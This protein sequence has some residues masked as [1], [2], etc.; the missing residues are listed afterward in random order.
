MVSQPE[1]N[2]APIPEIVTS[3]SGR[4]TK[5]QPQVPWIALL[6]I[7]CIGIFYFATLRSGHTWGDDFAMYVRH[8]KNLAEGRTYSDTGYIYNPL[9]PRLGPPTY[10]PVFPL[11]LTP[12]YKFA[13]L[14][15]VALKVVAVAC[16]LGALTLLVFV[17]YRDLTLG[18]VV[19]VIAILGLNPFFFDYKDQIAS[20]LPFL[21]F[22]LIAL[23]LLD[24][25]DAKSGWPLALAAGLSICLCTATRAIGLALLPSFL[26]YSLLRER[27]ITAAAIRVSLVALASTALYVWSFRGPV[28]YLDQLHITAA[29]IGHNLYFQLWQIYNNLWGN[30]FS[31]ALA[32][33]L[34]ATLGLLG[35]FGYLLR[36]RRG[37][38]LA[39]VFLPLY[40]VAIILWPTE[41][42][43]R[44]LIPV[45]P[46]W[47][48][49]VAIAIEW[50]TKRWPGRN[51]R[52]AALALVTLIF[53]SYAGA[54]LHADF[55]PITEGVG[56][57]RFRELCDFI[58]TRTPPDAIFIFEKPRLL[59][60]L[61]SR[62]AS[63]YHDAADPGQI[64][65]YSRRIGA[66]YWIL[67]QASERD[68]QY[69]RP[70]M[71]NA[72]Q[73]QRVFANAGFDLYWI[74]PE[75]TDRAASQQRN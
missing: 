57:V 60:L 7:A 74:P 51:V 46:Y 12:V 22:V 28:S 59:S 62:R 36:W 8:A 66:S 32:V 15:W 73:A 53:A 54:Y 3:E 64:W 6:L 1:G 69:L 17:F 20:D 33:I 38:G 70:T 63:G 75:T 16:W 31:R 67:S 56:D 68:K 5:V 47:L 21:F 50:M 42:D 10:P 65:D 26:L 14:N 49:Y 19:G 23:I 9:Y 4:G 27:R 34:T 13:G 25:C 39:E 24:R 37:W 45:I 44:F 71:L 52:M 11:L 18:S 2:S 35:V 43:L 55:G 58:T 29:S 30:G 41:D 72:S 61:T 48:F 40:T